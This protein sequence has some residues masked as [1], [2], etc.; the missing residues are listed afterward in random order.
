MEKGKPH[1][2][3]VVTEKGIEICWSEGAWVFQS[4][5]SKQSALASV[6]VRKTYG[7]RPI[8]YTERLSSGEE[9]TFLLPTKIEKGSQILEL[10]LTDLEQVALGKEIPPFH[11]FNLSYVVGAVA[12]HCKR[13]AEVYCRICR[14]FV[15]FPS[16]FSKLRPDQAI[17]G[18]Q[19]EPYYEF[20]E[21]VTAAR[22]SYDATRHIIWRAFGPSKGP[23]PKSFA[24]TFR[25]CGGLPT[26]LAERLTSSWSQFGERVTE[27]RD[28]IQHYVPIGGPKPFARMQRLPGGVWSTTCWIPD[29]PEV[30][31]HRT[32]RYDSK[33]DALTYGWELTNEI[34]D[35]A[36]VLVREVPDLEAV[37]EGDTTVGS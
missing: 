17:Y 36:Q 28:C 22:R 20:E 1:I 6:E 3:R 18:D 12:Y 7:V 2:V 9:R 15:R 34:L 26:T 31:S 30:R 29:N 23:V 32:F 37:V 21:L 25:R 5:E 35:I 11:T 14:D 19:P 13:L 10:E 8:L 16:P 33:L 27:Y 24:R 4:A